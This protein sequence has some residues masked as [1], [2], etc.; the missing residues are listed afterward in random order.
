[1]ASRLDPGSSIMERSVKCSLLP[2]SSHNPFL[3]KWLFCRK[4]GFRE[5]KYVEDSFSFLLNL[6]V[7][8]YFRCG[9]RTFPILK[10]FFVLVCFNDSR[11]EFRYEV[12]DTLRAISPQQ[13][14]KHLHLWKEAEFEPEAQQS[15][16]WFSTA[17]LGILMD[18][19][20]NTFENSCHS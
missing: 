16:S 3:K 6:A 11:L 4:P 5:P 7:F 20:L 10:Q 9:L 14:D 13:R 18:I 8:K 19:P 17:F 2:M 15:R 12:Y 1:M